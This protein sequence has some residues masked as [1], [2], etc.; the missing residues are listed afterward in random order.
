MVY[1]VFISYR[2][3]DG[4]NAA[5]QL[6]EF[7]KE[8]GIKVFFDTESIVDG[9]RWTTQIRDKLI[10]ATHYILVGTKSAFEF[11][12]G[13]DWVREE[14]KLAL[15]QY[16][17]E[18]KN[19]TITVWIPE[20]N[21][22]PDKNTLPEEVREVMEYNA[23]D[24][25]TK[26]AFQRIHNVVTAVSH[27][28]L[29]HGAHRWLQRS[30]LPGGRFE[31]ARVD[32]GLLPGAKSELPMCVLQEQY[33]SQ[34]LLDAVKTS[35]S[36]IF[37]TGQG[38]MGKTTAL[39]KIMQDAYENRAYDQKSIVP[40]FVELSCAP[41]TNGQLYLGGNSSF[42][43]RAIYRQLRPDISL[44]Q[45]SMAAVEELDEVFTMPYATAVAPIDMLLGKDTDGPEYLL[46]LDGLNEVSTVPI[47]EVG[48]TVSEMITDEIRYLSGCSN[49]RIVLT[50]R[51]DERELPADK[52]TRLALT[53]LDYD[54]ILKYLQGTGKPVPEAVYT[55]TD[56]LQTLQIP[57]F[58]ILYAELSQKQDICTQGQILHCYFSQTGKGNYTMRNRLADVSESTK[59]AAS[60]RS[61]IRI[62][63]DMHSF[64][65]ELI[66]P[67]IGWYMEKNG[68]FHITRHR[69][70]KLIW[71]VLENR[72]EDGVCGE[73]GEDIFQF[74]KSNSAMAAD[75]LIQ[76]LGGAEKADVVCEQIINCFSFTMGILLEN[77]KSL[78]FAHQHFR[79]YFAAKKY[80]NTLI[81]ALYIHSEDEKELAYSY[82]SGIFGQISV[83]VRRMIG[84][85]LAEDRNSP[86]KKGEIYL[87]PVMEGERRLL[88]D[89][90]SIFRGQL[91]NPVPVATLI[92][93][94]KDTR[95]VLA[96][97]DLSRLDLRQCDLGGGVLCLPGLS[98]DLTGAL[99]T[100][101]CLLHSGHSGWISC[102][103]HTH[104]GSGILTGGNDGSVLL[105]DSLTGQRREILKLEGMVWLACML[106]DGRLLTVSEDSLRN[107]RYGSCDGVT[108]RLTDLPDIRQ[109]VKLSGMPGHVRL[110]RD[111]KL[112][113]IL[114]KD[115]CVVIDVE[116]MQLLRQ[117]PAP[118]NNLTAEFYG[119]THEILFTDGRLIHAETG[120][121]RKLPGKQEIHRAAFFGQ[122]MCTMEV[123]N[124]YMKLSVFRGDS[125]AK[126]CTIQQYWQ[127]NK[128][129][130]PGVV[131]YN[132][133][134]F[135]HVKYSENGRFLIAIVP[136]HTYVYETQQYALLHCFENEGI[137]DITFF[138]EDRRLAAGT[139]EGQ[140]VIYETAGFTPVQQTQ[141]ISS[142]I[143]GFDISSNGKYLAS[144]SMD[145]CLR[146]WNMKNFHLLAQAYIGCS[147][148]ERPLFVNG[149]KL[150]TLSQYKKANGDRVYFKVPAL[151][152]A[153]QPNSRNSNGYRVEKEYPH[154]HE[155]RVFRG[156]EQLF[157][158]YDCMDYRVAG[159]LLFTRV[160]EVLS[161]Q[162]WQCY[163]I[164][165]GALLWRLPEGLELLCA[166]ERYFVAKNKAFDDWDDTEEKILTV[167]DCRNGKQLAGAKY[168][169]GFSNI[170]EIHGD[171][172]LRNGLR[173]ASMFKLPSLEVLK[174]FD[175]QVT[176]SQDEKWLFC[177]ASPDMSR[178]SLQVFRAEDLRL[179]YQFPAPA[180]IPF[181]SNWGHSYLPL[182]G[183]RLLC[184]DM[185]G[186][187]I[188]LYRLNEQ[189]T[190]A[191]PCQVLGSIAIE[192]GLDV[193]GLDLTQLHP[194]SVITQEQAD[195]LRRYGAHL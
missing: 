60:A 192:P 53:G 194:S 155:A 116:N 34:E 190:M 163:D 123:E 128:P 104:D 7:L 149:D 2:R 148:G 38:G 64:L 124:T 115:E 146:L 80:I 176:R 22:L 83:T 62:E 98:A 130:R 33:G 127:E 165:T 180:P 44:K 135:L 131:D 94:L 134:Q 145:G 136:D 74:G 95:K 45:V 31:G 144:C 179:C 35:Q 13:E 113:L 91:M 41:D 122:D 108:V 181:V 69:L 51:T 187:Q 1:D 28:N 23:V 56:L 9:H 48:R 15:A 96:G 82:A 159:T 92:S 36:H 184:L 20:G 139:M 153:K 141:S 71:S 78:T 8:M 37:L 89:A 24:G 140:L 171:R 16:D 151:Q 75:K 39:L 120:K 46:L 143:T 11:R 183:D 152:P 42:I 177:E 87:L 6:H 162:Y 86:V 63:P 178:I 158:V 65:L 25:A 4:K 173:D 117:I 193:L 67:E 81:L 185:Y 169:S 30:Q 119:N 21:V 54:S 40:L 47:H 77:G 12:A 191:V 106:R 109:E 170:W 55:D 157:T 138:D 93:I 161:P 66:L 101:D 70:R 100:G 126:V 103:S 97:L 29:W 5:S 175:G 154:Y 150:I 43:R 105:H 79:D 90:L 27:A 52:F 125:C 85:A 160:G 129:Y 189:D 58:L 3:E 57:L 121:K 167:Y 110:S 156:K 186:R 10:A 72:G 19:R 107:V 112:L 133:N 164:T 168:E 76:R 182:S 118:E 88:T 132:V 172:L 166:D 142:V 61:K 137:D 84:E 102:V 17:E 49:V 32:E 188:R 99:L 50:G 68:Q 174:H 73:F 26:H 114:L 111:E 14:I 147:M 195:R 18:T 59:K